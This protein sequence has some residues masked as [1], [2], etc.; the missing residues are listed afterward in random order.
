M[1]A[2]FEI[3]L[4]HRW[5]GFALDVT[6]ESAAGGVCALFGPS[7]S[8][9]T[10]VIR[11]IAGLMQAQEAFIRIGDRV[12]TD[13]ARG[14]FVKPHERRVGYV[15]QDARLF[16]HLSVAQ[17]LAYGAR[18]QRPVNRDAVVDVLGIS[19]LL[20]RAPRDLSGGEAQRVAIGR[21]LLSAPDIL[22]MDEPLAA[23]DAPR[24][25]DILPYL[26]RLREVSQVQC[27]YVSHA[28]DEVARLADTLVLMREGRALRTGA[29][30]DI[31]SDPEAMP[32]IGLREAGSVIDVTVAE[33]DAGDGLSALNSS[34]GTL[35]LPRVDAASG[36][37]MRVRIRAADI[38]LSKDRPDGL[39]ALNCLPATITGLH[40]GAGPG[41]A[42]GLRSGT[43][44]LL[45][46]I[47]AR[48][49]RI[50]KLAEGGQVFAVIKTVSVAPG[51]VTRR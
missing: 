4:R 35:W 16:P 14:V 42:V 51:S 18:A 50:M 9:K 26:D 25:A 7:G 6:A 39:S 24:R 20:D 33:R 21:A 41:V 13:T 15:F 44:R 11:T 49:A 2:G 48:S 17:N 31:L 40:F 30:G 47:T 5:P 8:G 23:L 38:I 37:A 46:R 22:L 36:Q 12:L 3:R 45:A 27:F 32:E 10:S 43:D 28:M 19:A 34:A 1:S 29:L